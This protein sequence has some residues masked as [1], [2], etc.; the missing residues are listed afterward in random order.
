MQIG[1]GESRKTE[2]DLGIS[3]ARGERQTR[4]ARQMA[5]RWDETAGERRE[6]RENRWRMIEQRILAVTRKP[7]APVCVCVCVQVDERRPLSSL[8]PLI[9]SLLYVPPDSRSKGHPTK[10]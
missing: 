1:T 10:A 7:S 5:S 3:G 2:S 9:A 4:T 6:G 8:I